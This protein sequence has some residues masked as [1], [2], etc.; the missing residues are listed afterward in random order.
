VHRVNLVGGGGDR[1]GQGM[2][3]GT[4]SRG[5]TGTA[6]GAGGAQGGQGLTSGTTSN[7]QTGTI[8]G[9]AGVETTTTKRTTESNDTNVNESSEYYSKGGGVRLSCHMLCSS[10]RYAVC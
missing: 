8:T 6:V 7:S 4:T 1:G 3:S 5:Q 10:L 9:A 2:T